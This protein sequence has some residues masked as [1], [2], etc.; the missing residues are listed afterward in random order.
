MEFKTIILLRL[1]MMVELN[2]PYIMYKQQDLKKLWDQV[3]I[4]VNLRIYKHN[5]K[6][7]IDFSFLIYK[8]NYTSISYHTCWRRQLQ[9]FRFRL[10]RL[11]RSF[12]RYHQL[13]I[14]HQQWYKRKQRF[15][16][17]HMDLGLIHHE[18]RMLNLPFK[19]SCW[20]HRG[21]FHHRM[22]HHMVCSG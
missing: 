20:L 21:I 13:S 5:I 2:M 10:G 7:S 12:H 3:V 15:R 16:Y 19:P 4:S 6:S 14:N 17:L 18:H 1:I 9:H 11:H 22:Y 8:L